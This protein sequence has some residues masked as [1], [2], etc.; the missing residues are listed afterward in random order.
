MYSFS[1]VYQPTKLFDAL[2]LKIY[3]GE[4]L[5][6]SGDYAKTPTPVFNWIDVPAGSS[7]DPYSYL[8]LK[9]NTVVLVS[10][11]MG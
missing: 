10:P 1:I 11:E 5:A 7:V 3:L 9:Y 2:D 6:Y 8:L 4:D